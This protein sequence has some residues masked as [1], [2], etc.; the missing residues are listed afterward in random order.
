VSTTARLT[1]IVAQGG[2]GTVE[3]AVLHSATVPAKDFL[4]GELE[5][6]REKGRNDPQATARAR[7]MM[8]FQQMAEYGR[9][10]GKRFAKE[11]GKLFAFK[12]E[13]NNRQI[14]FPCFQDGKK[15]ILTHGFVKPGAQKKKGKWP[16]SEINRAHEIEAEYWIRKKQLEET[17]KR[18]KQ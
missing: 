16:Q 15:W 11:M 10:S 6:I 2:W 1:I 12:H 9:V 17:A 14:R 4:E 3:C 18:E 7:F 13:V 5:D 8:L